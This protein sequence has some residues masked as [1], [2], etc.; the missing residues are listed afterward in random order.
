MSKIMNKSLLVVLCLCFMGLF[1]FAGCDNT[2]KT[3]TNAPTLIADVEI[4]NVRYVVV[5]DSFSTNSAYAKTYSPHNGV[6]HFNQITQRI[7][8]Y[9]YDNYYK[10]TTPYD[11]PSEYCA[12]EY[13]TTYEDS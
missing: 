12:I 13:I 8:F 3:E 1:L 6:I 2:N 11:F 9:E 4:T 10:K 5:A 7:S